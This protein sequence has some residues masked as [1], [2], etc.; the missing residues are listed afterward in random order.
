MGRGG[1]LCV[2]R[3]MLVLSC[4][5]VSSA[6]ML[7]SRGHCPPVD[8]P[9][10]HALVVFSALIN[11]MP[12]LSLLFLPDCCRHKLSAY[13]AAAAAAGGAGVHLVQAF[14]LP[15]CFPPGVVQA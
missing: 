7:T 2:M 10:L 14:Y 3:V 9:W 15:A 11:M 1:A 6:S 12:C 13:A 4:C 5:L 8:A